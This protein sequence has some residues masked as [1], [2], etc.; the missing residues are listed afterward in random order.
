VNDIAR[1][2]ARSISEWNADLETLARSTPIEAIDQAIESY[3][4]AMVPMLARS[5]AE[6]QPDQIELAK[7]I[8]NIGAR[9][10]PDFTPDQAQ[11]WCTAMVD[12]LDE[13]PARVVLQAA[14]DARHDEIEFPGQ[15]H[16]AIK[17]RA[18][19]LLATHQSRIA[20]LKRM[21]RIAEQPPALE[22]SPEAKELASKAELEEMA[23]EFH[24]LGIAAGWLIED[25]DG[26]RWATDAEHAAHQQRIAHA[27]AKGG[28]A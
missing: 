10:R 22:A 14:R 25:H 4:L 21:R 26:I 2:L 6:N 15:V 24:R 16:K 12:A 3:Q 8:R 17:A 23:P 27:R 7:L 28:M 9:I 5:K 11:I 20:R 18:E 13:F 1:Q 19:K